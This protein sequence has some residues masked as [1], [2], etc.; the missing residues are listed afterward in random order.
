MLVEG[1]PI[2]PTMECFDSFL[3]R[4]WLR[5]KPT[6]GFVG[7]V[8]TEGSQL[9]DGV[10]AFGEGVGRSFFHEIRKNPRMKCQKLSTINYLVYKQLT[11]LRKVNN[12][13]EWC[14][15]M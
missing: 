3:L 1:T 9:A 12:L 4:K 13:L 8:L 14:S 15:Q 2:E 11:Y 7:L 6:N 10:G 5:E